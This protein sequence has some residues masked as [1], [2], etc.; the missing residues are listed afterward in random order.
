MLQEI[1]TETFRSTLFNFTVGFKSRTFDLDF[2]PIFDPHLKRS[3]FE[4][5]QHTGK[6]KC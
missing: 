6:L 1:L 5:E 3:G 4:M 2:R